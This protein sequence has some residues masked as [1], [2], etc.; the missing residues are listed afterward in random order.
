MNVLQVPAPLPAANRP[1][2][3]KSHGTCC[4]LQL[5]PDSQAPPHERPLPSFSS[6]CSTRSWAGSTGVSSSREMP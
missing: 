6:Y 1:G 3:L 5:P 4:H 2:Q